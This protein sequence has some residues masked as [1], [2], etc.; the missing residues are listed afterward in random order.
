MNLNKKFN[1]RTRGYFFLVM[2]AV[3][4][5]MGVGWGVLL[6]PIAGLFLVPV[7]VAT[8]YLS[9][10]SFRADRDARV[11]ADERSE[12]L[13]ERASFPA[14]WVTLSVMLA[15]FS[16]R[17]VFEIAHPFGV[18]PT[19][20]TIPIYALIGIGTFVLMNLYL[21]RTRGRR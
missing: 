8:L 7:V 5:V 13:V 10:R 18:A 20:T 9:H 14:F 21:R 19:G 2:A 17:S 6:D 12:R 1:E 11:T 4:G 15:E 3:L 16:L